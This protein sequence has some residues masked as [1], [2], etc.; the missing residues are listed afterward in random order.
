M[1]LDTVVNAAVQSRVLL[2]DETILGMA[3]PLPRFGSEMVEFGGAKKVPHPSSIHH[4]DRPS[5]EAVRAPL[6]GPLLVAFGAEG[7]RQSLGHAQAKRE[8]PSP[9]VH[10]AQ[11]LQGG[12][13]KERRGGDREGGERG[14]GKAQRT[15]TVQCWNEIRR[16]AAEDFIL[17]HLH[18]TPR[19]TVCVHVWGLPGGSLLLGARVSPSAPKRRADTPPLNA[20]TYLDACLILRV[21]EPTTHPILGEWQGD[22]LTS[23]STP[24][25]EFS[26]FWT[27]SD[28]KLVIFPR[29]PFETP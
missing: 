9:A 26:N 25:G 19:I 14:A 18:T 12:T 17:G 4:S 2:D 11:G 16:K 8:A 22:V 28:M 10:E 21:Q 15:H 27:A 3:L 20:S 5:W 29:P 13:Q 23:H 6:H 1:D 7:A 24:L